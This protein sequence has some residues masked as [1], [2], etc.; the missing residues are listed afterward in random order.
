MTHRRTLLAA[1]LALPHLANAQ[2]R[3]IR[4]G[5]TLPLSGTYASEG[6]QYQNGI[7][8]FQSL[9]GTTVAGRPV[10]V[11][12]RDDQGIAGDLARRLLQEMIAR[13][14]VDMVSG[15]SFTPTALSSATLVTQA[16]KPAIIMNAA[17]S[18]VTE[19][20]PYFVRV[21]WTLPQAAAT[22]GAWAARNGHK[23]VFSLV[24]DYAPGLDAET[25]FKRSFTAAGGEVIGESRMPLTSLEYAPYL[26]RVL[27]A[28]PEAVFAFL[29]GGDVS[30]AFLRSWRE[31]G[32]ARAGIQM[33]ATGDVVED[34]ILT[35]LGEAASG[36]ISVHHYSSTHDSD[37][38]RA[39]VAAY[40]GM[41][42]AALRPNFRAVQSYDGMAAMYRALE[43]RGGDTDPDALME[44][45]KGMRVRSPRG[46]FLIEADTRDITQTMYIRRTEQVGGQWVNTEFEAVAN[47][48]DP[49]KTP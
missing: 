1:G 33:L 30:A 9:H 24:S 17:T 40:H 11:L 12:I 19:R 47:V 8:L 28:R 27:D 6:V 48:R 43:L 41:F 4:I 37:D 39:F 29:P 44:Q 45:F 3:V 36:V 42:G 32:L 5:I 25:W 35:T 20:S 49:G 13:E 46:E 31:R 34:D 15:F 16:R 21:S 2:A 7:R 18:I 26:Q 14:R 10:E 22:I 38:N 23:R